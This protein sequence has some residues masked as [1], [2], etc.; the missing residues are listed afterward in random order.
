[1]VKLIGWVSKTLLLVMF[2][3][4]LTLYL[5]WMTVHT[6]MDRILAQ[7]NINMDESKIEFT[8][9][10][11]HLSD[12]WYTL[13]PKQGEK[14]SMRTQDTSKVS[15]TD[16]QSTAN[17]DKTGIVP[18]GN[19]PTPT[20]QSNSTNS[21]S[22]GQ[23]QGSNPTIDKLPENALPVFNQK[24]EAK[25]NSSSEKSGNMMMSAEQFHKMKEQLSE[26]DKMKVFTLLVAR[27][28]EKEMQKISEQVENGVTEEEWKSIQSAVITYLKPDEYQQLLAIMN[29]Y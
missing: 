19:S 22:Q 15:K 28:P 23:S 6:Y 29:K 25:Q 17:A 8:Q 10:L 3:S 21:Q 16:T 13:K 2:I 7:Y 18:G 20:T 26:K 14:E 11:S 5:T 12:S 24:I 9:L 1:M 27:L 4:G